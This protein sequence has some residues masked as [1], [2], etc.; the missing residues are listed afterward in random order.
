M[1]QE[2]VLIICFAPMIMARTSL[3]RVQRRNGLTRWTRHANPRICNCVTAEQNQTAACQF[4]DKQPEIM[5]SIAHITC[6]ARILSAVT[7]LSGVV[8]SLPTSTMLL[9]HVER[10]IK[11]HSVMFGR[12]R[13]PMAFLQFRVPKIQQE[14][15][16][17]P[18]R[19]TPITPENVQC[20]TCKEC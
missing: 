5:V 20:Q 7:A 2:F 12:V 9:E 18:F 17:A 4:V 8:E 10:L 14:R 13:F 16:V 15:R 1:Y 19:I 11:C 6:N 3:R